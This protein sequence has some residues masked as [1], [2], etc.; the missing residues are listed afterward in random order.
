[1]SWSKRLTLSVVV[2]ISNTHR[3]VSRSVV[4]PAIKATY[5]LSYFASNGKLGKTAG[6]ETDFVVL[7]FVGSR[8]AEE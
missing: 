4:T 3:G 7:C 6:W 1:M 5:S 8:G 2:L